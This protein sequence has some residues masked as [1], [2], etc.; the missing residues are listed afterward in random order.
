MDRTIQIDVRL[1]QVTV[2]APPVENMFIFQVEIQV[3]L[4]E[5]ETEADGDNEELFPLDIFDTVI[6]QE[7]EVSDSEDEDDGGEVEDNFSDLSSD[8]GSEHDDEEGKEQETDTKL[9]RDMVTKLDCILE[10]IFK[11]LDQ[12][13]LTPAKLT[14]TTTDGTTTPLTPLPALSFDT[15]FTRPASPIVLVPSSSL[16]HHRLPR[17]LSIQLC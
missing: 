6:G 13:F 5:L 15:S 12:R 14:P 3:E 4:E 2:F 11:H 8:A 7:G 1:S 9:V 10:V 17:P 16:H